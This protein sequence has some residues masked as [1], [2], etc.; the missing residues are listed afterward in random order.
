MIATALS[1]AA[2]AIPSGEAASDGCEVDFEIESA[3]A[4]ASGSRLAPPATYR[5]VTGISI[6]VTGNTGKAP[7]A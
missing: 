6:T 7:T 4:E 2:P 3:V 1:V 5:P